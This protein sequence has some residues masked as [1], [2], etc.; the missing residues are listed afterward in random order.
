M[1]YCAVLSYFTIEA[2]IAVVGEFGCEGYRGFSCMNL[3]ESFH[4]VLFLLLFMLGGLDFEIKGVGIK[5]ATDKLFVSNVVMLR[6]I[7]SIAVISV[8]QHISDNFVIVHIRGEHPIHKIKHTLHNKIAYIVFESFLENPENF[9]RAHINFTMAQIPPKL[10]THFF[11]IYAKRVHHK[12]LS[13]IFFY[14]KNL[15]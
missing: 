12:L 5:V 11:Q 13:C 8:W 15:H 10:H 9:G 4:K 6:S 2:Y 3:V 7:Y 14:L 1:C